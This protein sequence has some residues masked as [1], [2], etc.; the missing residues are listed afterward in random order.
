M[1][2]STFNVP[3][4]PFI[5]KVLSSSFAI[6]LSICRY[7]KKILFAMSGAP[8]YTKFIQF[9]TG[10]LVPSK[11]RNNPKFWPYFCNAIGAIYGSHIPIAPQHTCMVSSTTGKGSFPRMHS[12]LATLTSTLRIHS[13]DGKDLQWTHAC[14]TTQSRLIYASP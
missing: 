9:P 4:I 11:I 5:G 8:F 13:L 12:S 7:F 3:M 6:D 1:L 10:E 14:M 2:E